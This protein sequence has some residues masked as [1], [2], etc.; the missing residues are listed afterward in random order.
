MATPPAGVVVNFEL[1]HIRCGKPR[2]HCMRGSRG[3]GP[4]WYAFWNDPKTG[5][6]KSQY[7]GKRFVPPTHPRPSVHS[8]M[9]H[10]RG[11]RRAP[12]PPPPPPRQPPP[13]TRGRHAPTPTQDELDAVLLGVTLGV[14]HAELKK[15][16]RSKLH[17]AHPD[18][19]KEGKERDRQEEIAKT[20]NQAYQR[21]MKR[22]GWTR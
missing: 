17:A 9:P 18:R 16:W 22:R 3:H 13:G 21:M 1:L 10:H 2:C 14:T 6:K 8:T 11:A 5:V 19:Y 12:P 15:A 7:K 20:I 4:Y